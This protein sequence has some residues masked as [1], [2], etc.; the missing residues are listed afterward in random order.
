M[1]WNASEPRSLIPRTNKQLFLFLFLSLFFTKKVTSFSL[2]SLNIF[3]L[4]IHAPHPVGIQTTAV[5]ISE[6]QNNN[7]L[8]QF[9]CIY[10]LK[11][12]DFLNNKTAQLCGA[13]DLKMTVG[14]QKHSK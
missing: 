3:L 9:S 14:Q 7:K 12:V 13:F 2:V 11:S 1:L 8:G 6:K 10:V 5:A 4:V